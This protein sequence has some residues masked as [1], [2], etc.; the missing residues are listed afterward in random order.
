MREKIPTQQNLELQ[1]KT[2]NINQ[3]FYIGEYLYLASKTN[4]NGAE[5]TNI[6]IWY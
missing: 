3:F 2:E 1:I 4:M 5:E 6:R